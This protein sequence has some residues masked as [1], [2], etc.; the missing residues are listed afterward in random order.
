[1]KTLCF[2]FIV[3]NWRNTF[4]NPQWWSMYSLYCSCFFSNS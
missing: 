3:R 4:S 2:A 1:L